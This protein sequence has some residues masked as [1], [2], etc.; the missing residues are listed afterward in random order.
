MTKFENLFAE[1]P[2][3]LTDDNVKSAVEEILAKHFDENNNVE[4]WKKGEARAREFLIKSGYKVYDRKLG[5]RDLKYKDI[6]ILLRSTSVQAPIYEKELTKANLPVFS[7]TSSTYLDS[8]EVQII[9]SLL[10]IIDN[11]MQ[12]IPLV[13]V[14][15]SSIGNFDDNELISYKDKK[16]KIVRDSSSKVI[17]SVLIVDSC[18]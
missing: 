11:P 3:T 7:D 13:T 18:E 14:L 6:V 12:D 4:V 1:Y 15:R 17:T 16:I 8:M 10:K 5:V 2:C 9:M